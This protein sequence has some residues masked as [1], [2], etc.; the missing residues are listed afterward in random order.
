MVAND[1]VL[2]A[3]FLGVYDLSTTFYDNWLSRTFPLCNPTEVKTVTRAGSPGN[4]DIFSPPLP[5]SFSSL[6]KNTSRNTF[7]LSTTHQ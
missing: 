5:W 3:C 4:R 6:L 1:L 2:M 7:L